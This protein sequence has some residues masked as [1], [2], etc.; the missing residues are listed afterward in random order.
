MKVVTSTTGVLAASTLLADK[1]KNAADAT[2]YTAQLV[3][4]IVPGGTEDYP[5]L[6]FLGYKW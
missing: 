6:D 3:K 4:D 5:G 2:T 1:H